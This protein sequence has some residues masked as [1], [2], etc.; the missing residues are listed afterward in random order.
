M[1][2]VPGRVLRQR[3]KWLQRAAYRLDALQ[4]EAGEIRSGDPMARIFA[5]F[6][7]RSRIE[8]PQTELMNPELVSIGSDVYVRKHL[9]IE[10]Y[11][12]RGAIVVRFGNQIQCGYNVRL[13]AF[14]G[15]E[16]A[17]LVGIGHGST[18]SDS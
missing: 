15:I 17:D 2:L 18:I 10:A 8:W 11:G 13:V 5:E 6:G 4:R 12:P 7:A 3:R 1:K 9:C 14:N 16:I